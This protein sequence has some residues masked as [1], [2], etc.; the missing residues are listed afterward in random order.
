[1]ETNFKIIQKSLTN[2]IPPFTTQGPI[3]N[4]S[5]S[6][7]LL[8]FT[9]AKFI[10]NISSAK[11]H[12]GMNLVLLNYKSLLLILMAYNTKNIQRDTRS[13]LSVLG[14][15]IYWYSLSGNLP[16]LLWLWCQLA[17]VH[18]LDRSEE[19]KQG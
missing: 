17:V 4:V 15:W 6:S 8:G 1:M 2:S 19:N 14:P 11:G 10:Q 13:V 9:I 7:P 18:E 16:V 3:S 12:N 5:L